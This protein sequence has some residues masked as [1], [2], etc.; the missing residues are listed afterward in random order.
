M[1]IETGTPPSDGRYIIWQPIKGSTYAEPKIVDRLRGN[2]LWCNDAPV[3]G[4]C[5]PLPLRT[6]ASFGLSWDEV[7]SDLRK[8]EHGSFV[9]DR[10]AQE[11][12]L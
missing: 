1:K 12:D 2:W 5:G 9:A 10:P 6:I 3:L 8:S 4:W 7:F 11:Y